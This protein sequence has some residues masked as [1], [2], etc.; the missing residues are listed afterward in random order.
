MLF[1]NIYCYKL[2]IK[3]TLFPLKSTFDAE[4]ILH[5]QAILLSRASVIVDVIVIAH[6]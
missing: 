6:Q 4:Y 1:Q 5:I 3:K 2:I